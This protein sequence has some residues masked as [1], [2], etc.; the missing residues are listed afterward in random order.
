MRWEKLQYSIEFIILTSNLTGL[1]CLRIYYG[2]RVL[3]IFAESFFYCYPGSTVAENILCTLA[4]MSY[5]QLFLLLIK[6]TVAP[7]KSEVFVLLIIE[8]CSNHESRRLCEYVKHKVDYNYRVY[9]K[10]CVSSY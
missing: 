1:R 9:E 4:E 3:N 6:P 10:S 2:I 8:Y 7:T 5:M